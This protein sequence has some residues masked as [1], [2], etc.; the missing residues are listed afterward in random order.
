MPEHLFEIFGGPR[1]LCNLMA[2]LT[3]GSMG[4]Q[5]SHFEARLHGIL[6]HEIAVNLDTKPGVIDKSHACKIEIPFDQSIPPV[7][8]FE[9]QR[10]S[11][12]VKRGDHLGDELDRDQ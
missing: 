9:H 10:H 2:P 1:P 12:N 5:I 4:D 3:A 11:V 7:R 8:S 6:V